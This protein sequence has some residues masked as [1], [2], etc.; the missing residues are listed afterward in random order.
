MRDLLRLRT[1]WRTSSA[2]LTLGRLL[3]WLPMLV[4]GCGSGEQVGAAPAVSQNRVRDFDARAGDDRLANEATVGPINERDRLQDMRL[5]RLEEYADAWERWWLSRSSLGDHDPTQCDRVSLTRAAIVA[6]LTRDDVEGRRAAL[7]SMLY[8]EV[9]TD[10]AEVVPLVSALVLVSDR[11]VISRRRAALVLGRYG[12]SASAAVPT[13]IEALGDEE[14]VPEAMR[15]LREIGATSLP[16]L[17]GAIR[18][19][20]SWHVRANALVLMRQLCRDEDSVR[21]VARDALEDEDSR[22]RETAAEVLE[23]VAGRR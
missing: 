7:A 1:S 18:S 15:A 16:L 19:G 6:G 10:G 8:D 23:A 22:V 21:G 9:R 12:A 11:D 2:K 17:E 14:T 13:L 20:A 3:P 5:G 4:L